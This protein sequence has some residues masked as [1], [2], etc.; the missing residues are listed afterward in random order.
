MLLATATIGAMTMA[1]SAHFASFLLG[2]EILSISLYVLVGY[3]EEHHAPLEAALKY[4]LLSGVASTTMLFGMALIY[5][6]TGTL[7]FAALAEVLRAGAAASLYLIV[8]NALLLAG[9]A[10]K[11]S[12]VPFHMWTPDVYEGAPAPVDRLSRDRRQ[13]RRVRAAAALRRGVGRARKR[14]AVL[15]GVGCCGALDGD[16]Q[17]AGATAAERQTHPRV[18]VDRTS[19]LP[20]D[21]A[22]R[23]R[24]RRRIVHSVSRPRSSI[25][26]PISR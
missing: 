24:A 17:S 14:T 22:A 18:L 10:F 23:R 13:R 6:D 8:G 21:R 1:S 9:I 19:R 25:S 4:L 15:R 16:R 7:E 26:R 11:L 12:L 20:A 5:L 2:L 3:P